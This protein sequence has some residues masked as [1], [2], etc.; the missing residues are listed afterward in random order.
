MFLRYIVKKSIHWGKLWLPLFLCSSLWAN[1]PSQSKEWLNLLHIVGS[2]SEIDSNDFFLSKSHEPEDELK[3]SIEALNSDHKFGKLKSPFA[4]AYPARAKFIEKNFGKKAKTVCPE[5]D[6]WLAGLNPESASIVFSSYYPNNPASIFG[7]TFIKIN[8]SKENKISDYAINYLAI[9]SETNGVLF[10]IKGLLGFYRGEF[11]VIPYFLKVNEYNHSESRDLYEYHLTLTK[12][13]IDTML[14]HLWEL[15]NNGYFDYYFLDDNCSYFMLGL[16]DVARTS[17]KLSKSFKLDVIPAETIKAIY[18]TGI[19]DKIDYRPSLYTQLKYRLSH[20][21]ETSAVKKIDSQIQLKQYQKLGQKRW[22]PEDE[23]QYHELLIKRSQIKL[24]SQELKLEPHS[25]PHQTHGPKAIEI[26]SGIINEAVY[27]KIIFKP[28]VHDFLD[29]DL[30]HLPFSRMNLAQTSFRF[31]SPKKIS[32]DQFTLID[33]MTLNAHESWDSKISWKAKVEYLEFDQTFCKSCAT[34][35][36]QAGIGKSLAIQ[37]SQMLNLFINTHVLYGHYFQKDWAYGFYPEISHYLSLKHLRSEAS[38]SMIN[39][40][41][42]KKIFNAIKFS[43]SIGVDFNNEFGLKVRINYY[44]AVQK[45]VKD[46]SDYSLNGVY[47]F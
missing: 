4:C 15:E 18:K 2:T 27:T 12:D 38:V 35:S 32:F 39:R 34:T 9:T 5:L 16:L 42:H 33:V 23:K 47:Y 20:K 43:E 1:S 10:G 26:G 13:E 14:R 22:S 21:K 17:L 11:S 46:R 36:F 24:P 29:S 19:V 6:A 30:G 7:H 41:D 8:T 3:A 45:N 44:Q 28:G 31:F 40:F 25:Y 37:K